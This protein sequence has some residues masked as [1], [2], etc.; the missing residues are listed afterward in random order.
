MPGNFRREALAGRIADFEDRLRTLFGRVDAGASPDTMELQ[1]AG[2]ERVALVRVTGSPGRTGALG[3][4]RDHLV[5]WSL[6]APTVFETAE[7]RALESTATCPVLLSA[8]SSYSYR[9][10]SPRLTLLSVADAHLRAVATRLQ[11]QPGALTIEEL[12][13][14]DDRAHRLGAVVAALGPEVIADDTTA[15]RRDEVDRRIAEAVLATFSIVEWT[16]SNVARAVAWIHEHA[17][18][19]I[20]TVEIAT[21][22]GLGPRALQEN[23]QAELGVTPTQYVRMHRLDR[24]RADLLT[25]DG[26]SITDVARRWGFNHLGRFAG[27]YAERFGEQPSTTRSDAMDR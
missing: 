25:G 15:E 18:Q 22:I 6:E 13:R 12:P 9:V 11:D 24:V 20:S 14:D 27:S 1:R 16:G 19:P 21:A 26:E 17:Q 23:F 4:R 8:G 10:D 7:G 5:V 3:P 2:D